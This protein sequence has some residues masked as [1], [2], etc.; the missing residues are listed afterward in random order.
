MLVHDGRAAFSAWIF[1]GSAPAIAARDGWF[2]LPAGVACMEDSLTH[3]DYRGRGFAPAAGL[4]IFRA[5]RESG[6][7]QVVTKIETSNGSSR[8][9]AAKAGFREV[10]T[11]RFKRV[12]PRRRT[13]LSDVRGDVGGQLASALER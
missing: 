12:G 5:V 1:H 6:V 4:G 2:E 9:A 7:V 3:P 8:R 10:A 11:M 13:S